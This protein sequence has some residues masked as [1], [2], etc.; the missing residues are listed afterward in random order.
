[1][2]APALPG[3]PLMLSGTAAVVGHASHHPGDVDAQFD[4]TLRNF[5]ALLGCARIHAPALPDRFGPGSLLKAYVRR[6][7]DPA[8]VESRLVGVGGAEARALVLHADVCRRELLVEIDGFH[9]P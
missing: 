1:M 4:E 2:L 7:A 3:L 8:R 5:D 6:E 9:A